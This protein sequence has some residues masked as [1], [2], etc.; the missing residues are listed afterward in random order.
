MFRRK[1]LTAGLALLVGGGIAAAM[2]GLAAVGQSSPPSSPVVLQNTAQIV[3]RG[4][5]A[6]ASVLVVCQP[7]DSTSLTVS[8]S[9]KSGN[10]IAEGSAFQ[11]QLACTGEIETLIVPITPTNKPFVKGTALGQASFTDCTYQCVSGSDARS[12]TL[13]TMLDT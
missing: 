9:E 12:V 10:G 6:L 5:A 13:S 7:G 4:A 2:P 8:L 1:W 11:S 3:N